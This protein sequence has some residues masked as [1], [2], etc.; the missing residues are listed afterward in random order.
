MEDLSLQ[1]NQKFKSVIFCG[2][3]VPC[4]ALAWRSMISYVI[5]S[6]VCG[7][8]LEAIT[9]LQ[10]PFQL[11]TSLVIYQA[12]ALAD[13]SWNRAKDFQHSCSNSDKL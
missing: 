9:F 3:M 2:I 12:K 4:S 6:L 5:A 10:G 1:D 7:D 11:S 8:W 13:I